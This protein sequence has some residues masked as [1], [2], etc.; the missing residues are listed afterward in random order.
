MRKALKKIVKLWPWPL[1]INERYD[2][3]TNA[4]LKKICEPDSIC[5]DIGWFRGDILRLMIQ[6]APNARH[7]AFEPIPEQYMQLRDQFD[8]NANIYPYALGNETSEATFNHVVTNPTYSGLQKR[9]YK[10]PEKI[11]EIVV[12]VRRLDEVISHDIPVHLIK[13]DVEGGEHDVLLGAKSILQKWHP[14]LIFEHGLGGADKYGVKPGD[15]YALL[16]EQTGYKICLMGDYL[17][18][19]NASGFTKEAFEEQFWSGRNCYFLAIKN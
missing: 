10:G 15:I 4:V 8:K 18:N 3:Q 12:P 17:K 14:Y 2:R 7:I 9:A 19:K 11:N 1:T 5:V 16:V 13:I 6:Y